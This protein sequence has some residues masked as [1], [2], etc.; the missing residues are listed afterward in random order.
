MGDVNAEPKA[1]NVED[2]FQQAAG[3]GLCP[4]AREGVVLAGNDRKLAR[5][6][7]A[8][9]A[10]SLDEVPA[11]NRL[12]AEQLAKAGRLVLEP[13]PSAEPNVDFLEGDDV[14]APHDSPQRADVEDAVG[15][16]RV[17]NVERRQADRS[18]PGTARAMSTKPST[19]RGRR[20]RIGARRWSPG[21]RIRGKGPEGQ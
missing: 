2:G 16:F 5:E 10:V 14:G 11:E 9:L 8:V 1:V 13:A 20:A 17:V 19:D 7:D 3:L 4:P 12:S 21:V 15:P 18:A 6:G